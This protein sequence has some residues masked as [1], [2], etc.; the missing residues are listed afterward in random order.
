M[1]EVRSMKN[2]LFTDNNKT[3]STLYYYTLGYVQ[4]FLREMPLVLQ[5]SMGNYFSSGGPY[6]C[7]IG[8]YMY[9]KKNKKKTMGYLTVFK[10]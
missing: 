5:A 9:T 1:T 3:G 7:L 4:H 10:I 8:S 2:L 6:F